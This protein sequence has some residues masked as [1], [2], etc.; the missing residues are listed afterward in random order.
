MGERTVGG[1]L[2]PGH[3]IGGDETKGT[4]RPSPEHRCDSP[5]GDG[6]CEEQGG[7][8][9][10]GNGGYVF[11]VNF[12]PFCG[13]KAPKQIEEEREQQTGCVVCLNDGTVCTSMDLLR[14]AGGEEADDGD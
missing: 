10:T 9:V 8:W 1:Y 3:W 2:I 14:R 11:S 5:S 12:C 4:K 13:A 7:E 6:F